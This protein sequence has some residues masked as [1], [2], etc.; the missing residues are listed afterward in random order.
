MKKKILQIQGSH[1]EGATDKQNDWDYSLNLV[2]L[3][4]KGGDWTSIQL[5]LKAVSYKWLREKSLKSVHQGSILNSHD[6]FN[7]LMP[8]LKFALI[9]TSV[10]HT[11]V[12][13]VSK[14]VLSS[15]PLFSHLL[16][17]HYLKL[18]LDYDKKIEEQKGRI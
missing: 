13:A 8:I 12:N 11:E 15:V 17:Q 9:K 5:F 3:V 10:S 6:D 14:W 1:K 18:F 4:S 16:D 7:I 2:L